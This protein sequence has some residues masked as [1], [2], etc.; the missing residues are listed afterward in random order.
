M[1][2]PTY[3]SFR[4]AGGRFRP[5][6][7]HVSGGG[8]RYVDRETKRERGIPVNIYDAARSLQATRVAAGEERTKLRDII[9]EPE[10]RRRWNIWK[11]RS[12]DFRERVEA[13]EYWDW[14]E[15]D[16]DDKW[17]YVG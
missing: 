14:W 8:H 12:R 1:A 3:H 10:F 11:D 9:K 6:R 7:G 4:D 15:Q 13:A 16:E 5:K 2:K 17:H